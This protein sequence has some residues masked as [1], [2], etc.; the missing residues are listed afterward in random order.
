M[1]SRHERGGG[2]D[3]SDSFVVLC[4]TTVSITA[5]LAVVA[6]LCFSQFWLATVI[7]DLVANRDDYARRGRIEDNV[8]VFLTGSK[9]SAAVTGIRPIAAVNDDEDDRVDQPS[10]SAAATSSTSFINGSNNPADDDHR[11]H[12]HNNS[13]IT[14]LHLVFVGDSVTR[15]QYL[16][17]AY[18][19]H[20]GHWCNDTS[21]QHRI[22][23]KN[24]ARYVATTTGALAPNEDCDCFLRPQAT[25]LDYQQTYVENRYYADP[26]RGNYVAYIGKWGAQSARGHWGPDTAFRG[27]HT[28][29]SEH[30]P[31]PFAWTYTW[32]ELI[33]LHLARLQPWPDYVV[34]NEGLSA[35]HSLLDLTTQ[36][37]VADALRSTGLVG[38]Y[39]TTT[40]TS[41]T[42]GGGIN[43]DHDQ[44]MCEL[45][46]HWL[47]LSWTDTLV[48]SAHRWDGLHFKDEVNHLMN[49][50]LLE[51]LDGIA[52]ST[53]RNG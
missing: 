29:L 38:I 21:F 26:V 32:S 9:N 31:E 14:N 18:Y 41:K 40:S 50:Q 23:K 15:Y 1:Q 24:L 33:T 52:P 34:L 49:Q 2:G 13:N 51:F 6:A 12:Y 45:L 53:E 37:A 7:V 16:D 46:D 10:Q 3:G 39:K 19:L 47:N 5:I 43:R 11:L 48:G 27:N 28:P 44:A 17:L 35:N 36:R 42:G 20:H 4:L 30:Q 8:A 22:H 25:A